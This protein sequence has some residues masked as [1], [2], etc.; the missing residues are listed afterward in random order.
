L[1]SYERSCKSYRGGGAFKIWLSAVLMLL[2]EAESEP[3]WQRG[4]FVKEKGASVLLVFA[5]LAQ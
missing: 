1:R 4:I 3:Q 5:S 2:V